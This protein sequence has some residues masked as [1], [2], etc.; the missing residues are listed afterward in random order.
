[1]FLFKQSGTVL[2]LS[3]LT[4]NLVMLIAKWTFRGPEELFWENV[5]GKILLE[6]GGTRENSPSFQ[7][8]V[9]LN[10]EC[11]QSEKYEEKNNVRL[12]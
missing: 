5:S 4:L 2:V 7:I 12:Q 10:L 6:R 1:M 9:V 8:W 3:L 11:G